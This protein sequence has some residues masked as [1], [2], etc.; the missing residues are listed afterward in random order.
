MKTVASLVLGL[1]VGLALF[2]QTNPTFYA[3][4]GKPA[5]YTAPH[6]PHTKLADVKAAHGGQAR[7]RQTVVDDVHL[8]SV[9]V[10]AQ[11]GDKEPQQLH[12]DTR[13]W[14][15]IQEGQIRFTIE[16][17]PAPVVAG[18]GAMVQ[19][20]MSTIFSMETIG[21]GPSL[22]F[23]TNIANAKTLF[24]NSAEAPK[25]PGF[26]FQPASFRRDNVG[27]FLHGNKP[28][29]TFDEVAQGVDSGKLKGTIRIVQDDRGTAN[30]IYG[31]NDKLPPLDEKNKGHWHPEGAEYWL[32]MKGQ[33][34]YPIENVGVV[35]AG[36]GDVVY[37][38]PFT[39]HAPRWW[40]EG[41]SCRLA[42]NGF[43]YIAHLFEAH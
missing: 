25:I 35:I 15:V 24:V 10:Q 16:G 22:R 20:P 33:I 13:T 19:V 6:K 42:M 11:P 28:Y 5:Q 39:Y 7:W 32:I 3:P 26:T 38:P 34:R 1:S 29:V 18:K 17:Q 2:S 40:G 9:W 21:T 31:R 8:N 23:E 12:P 27:V 37:V 4:K 43:P 30:F 36:E 41:A 14:W